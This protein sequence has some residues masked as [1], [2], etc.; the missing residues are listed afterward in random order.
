MSQRQV[1]AGIDFGGTSVKMALVDEGGAVLARASFPTHEAAHQ[2]AWLERVEAEI[3]SLM[4]KVNQSWDCLAGVGVGVPG[5]VDFEKGYIYDLTNVEGWTSVHLAESLSDR[6]HLPAY[7]DNDVNAMALGEC[8][9]GAGRVY[10]DAVFVT[11]GTGVGGGIVLDRHLYRGAYSM[12]GEIGHVSID[13]DGVCVPQGKGGLEQYIG[14]RQIVQR[15]VNALEEGRKSSIRETVKGEI[16]QITVKLIGEAA[17]N[18]DLLGLETFDYIAECLAT[19]FA[20]VTYLLQPEV[21][22]VGGGIALNGAI[23]FDPL[24]RHLQER[25]SPYFSERIAIRPAELGNDAGVIG[26]ASLVWSNIL[27]HHDEP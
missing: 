8:R 1:A 18:G 21:F 22:I 27:A 3:R 15:V 7:V 10:R 16:S 23:L 26:N 4:D 17:R 12:A 2:E 11:L 25:L 19:A 24:E 6:F 13:M 5:F 14:N 20:S 9:Y